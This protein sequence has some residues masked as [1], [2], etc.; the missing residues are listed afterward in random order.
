MRILFDECV[1]QK[2]RKDF[3]AYGH[4]VKTVQELGLSGKNERE[5]AKDERVSGKFDVYL[6]TE[7]NRFNTFQKDIGSLSQYKEQYPMSFII[8]DTGKG[9]HPDYKNVKPMM[10]TIQTALENANK[11]TL[12][13]AHRSGVCEFY[14]LERNRENYSNSYKS[15]IRQ[16]KQTPKQEQ[17]RGIT[18]SR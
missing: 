5:I 16:E 6:T 14:G 4:E 8:V 10:P 12:V 3:E 11:G 17:D 7:K 2:L 18:Y 15:E 1:N 9:V 13:K